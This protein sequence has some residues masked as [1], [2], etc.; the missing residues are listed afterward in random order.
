MHFAKSGYL[1]LVTHGKLRMSVLAI[2]LYSYVVLMYNIK[3]SLTSIY[4]N[5]GEVRNA[6]HLAW[7]KFRH[8]T[9]I[10][11]VVVI[12]RQGFVDCGRGDYVWI[13][14]AF[15]RAA[16]PNHKIKSL[17]DSPEHNSNVTLLFS[18]H[19]SMKRTLRFLL[20]MRNSEWTALFFGFHPTKPHSTFTISLC[21]L[22]SSFCPIFQ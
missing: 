11:S 13:K 18:D 20:K 14:L 17:H 21:T 22:Q 16:R 12:I 19:E 7:V 1:W 5:L 15:N 6:F 3:P 8:S 10:P 2:R 4:E 9:R